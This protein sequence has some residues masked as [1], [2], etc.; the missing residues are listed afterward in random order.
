MKIA[1]C[2]AVVD[3]K[4]SVLITRRSTSMGSFKGAWVL[5]GGHLDPGESLEE[6]SL[7]EL[8]EEAG[9]HISI[10]K[11]HLGHSKYSYNQ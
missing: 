6:C 5:P 4:Q 2:V 3:S 7:R 8:R 11:D 10:T 1:C 9:I